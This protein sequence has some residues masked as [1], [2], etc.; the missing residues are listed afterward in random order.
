MKKLL[1]YGLLMVVGL[2][3]VESG[4]A[5]TISLGERTPRFKQAKWL[6]GNVPQ[7]SD[8]T[9]IEFIHSASI[10]CRQSVERIH[11]IIKKFD[12]TAFVLISHQN[13]SEIDHWV[14][15]HIDTR[16]GVIIDD[17]HIRT[18]F[19]VNYA[20]YAVILDH[21]HRALWFGNPQLLNRATIEKLIIDN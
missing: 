21:K 19:G 5:Q 14:T 17:S 13:A 15:E 12:N 20:P 7:K 3:A 4:L 11:N 2:L 8:F 16:S 6:N 1:T 10:P 18:S 9:Y